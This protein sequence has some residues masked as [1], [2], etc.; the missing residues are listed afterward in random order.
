[1]FGFRRP[2]V[3]L[4]MAL[5]QPEMGILKPGIDPFRPW[6]GPLGLGWAPSG[7]GMGTFRPGSVP[8]RLTKRVLFSSIF[9]LISHAL[10]KK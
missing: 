3:Y 6:M 7:L 8:L 1:M 5:S 2:C 9:F 4:W 10:L